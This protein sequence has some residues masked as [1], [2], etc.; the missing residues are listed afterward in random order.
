M[1]V[2]VVGINEFVFGFIA[3]FAHKNAPATSIISLDAGM[4]QPDAGMTEL[5]AN[6]T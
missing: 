1:F 2:F 6:V 4:I 5:D 3:L